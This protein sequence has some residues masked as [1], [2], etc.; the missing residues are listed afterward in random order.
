MSNEYKLHLFDHNCGLQMVMKIDRN[1][2]SVL[3]TVS[4]ILIP[5]FQTHCANPINESAYSDY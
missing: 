5:L 3:D 2:F 4:L 1:I